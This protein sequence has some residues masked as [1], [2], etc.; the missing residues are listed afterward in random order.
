MIEALKPYP[1]YTDSQEPCLGV[2]P[3]H[4]DVKKLRQVGRLFK[5]VGGTKEDAVAEGVPC[6]RYGDL[7]TTHSYFIRTSR[8]YLTEER[9]REY[10]PMEYGDV[11][12]AGSGETLDDIGKSAVNLLT[13]PARCG[14]DLIMLRPTMTLHAPF[15]GYA[16]DSRPSTAQKAAMG[17]GTTVKHIYPEQLK[18]LAICL[19]PMNEQESI[20]RILDHADRRIQR[21]IRAK[22]KLI[23]L[24]NEQ[25]QA[26]VHRAV[27][28]GLDPN[29]RLKPSGVEWLGEVPEHWR[30]TSLKTVAEVQ[31]GL[32]LG[33]I[34][35]S[36]ELV[37]LPYLRVA[38][39]QAGY[40]EILIRQT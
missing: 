24:L 10:M 15:L 6:V 4:W 3:T 23:A 29:V 26:I 1:A 32:T 40:L 30:V 35:I 21:Y 37:E 31:S 17:R 16:T 36:P 25:K 20:V 27:T 39:V 18:N 7:Y 11:L 28:R 38:N 12:F 2:V 5:G 8:T 22:Q 9:A 34:Y 19:P 13:G 14:G 33:K